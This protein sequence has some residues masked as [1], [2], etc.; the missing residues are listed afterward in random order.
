MDAMTTSDLCPTHRSRRP[1]ALTVT[2]LV[3]VGA[4]AAGCGD[5]AD[6]AEPTTPDAPVEVTAIDYAY[7]DLPAEVAAGTEFRLVNDSEVEVHE[8]VAVRLDDDEERTVSELVQLPPA[9]F[10]GLLAG[11]ETVII[12]PPAADGTVVEGTGVL[13]EPGRYAIVCVIP[14][15]ADPDEYLAA[16]AEAEGGPPEVDGGPPHIAEGM[17]A[18]VVVTG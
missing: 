16:A 14:T 4:L 6:D 15:G 13:D 9:E 5:D 3:A 2:A 1:A 8:F 11:V 18:E 17:F 7:V 12:A 10:G